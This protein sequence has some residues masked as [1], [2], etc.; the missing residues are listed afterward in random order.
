MTLSHSTITPATSISL[1]SSIQLV[2]GQFN[3]GQMIYIVCVADNNGTSGASSTSA[4]LTSS[5]GWTY[6]SR[7]TAL[8]DPGA[9]AAG[10][11]LYAWTAR[12]TSTVSET[13]T[14]NFSPNTTAKVV[15]GGGLDS[16]AGYVDLST[17][18]SATGSGT[19][20]TITTGS[21]ASGDV[22]IGIVG[23]ES[24]AAVTADSDT[25]NG[26]WGTQNT[27]VAD[28]LTE[29]TSQRFARQVKTVTGSGTQTYN[30]TL[31]ASADYIIAYLHFTEVKYDGTAAITQANNTSS[32]TATETFTGT[33]TVTQENDTSSI[34]A[35]ETFTGTVAST[36]EDDTATATGTSTTSDII[37]NAQV[38][39][40]TLTAVS[41]SSTTTATSTATNA[42]L[43]LTANSG[44][45]TTDRT[46]TNQIGFISLSGLVGTTTTEIVTDNQ[47]GNLYL[48]AIAGTISQGDIATTPVIPW[49]TDKRKPRRKAGRLVGRTAAFDRPA[50]LTVNINCISPLVHESEEDVEMMLLL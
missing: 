29:A 49:P 20:P 4:T 41:N 17:T 9:A 2:A 35:T 23:A 28:T 38:A 44:T 16:T 27:A 31:G 21:L 43:G 36:Q 3:V 18:S 42:N 10:L 47:I 33:A 40:I 12:V 46:V 19:A 8:N 30:P 7:Q 1:T 37:V 5:N 50:R 14:V 39:N 13:V 48:T 26:S 6:T 22:V 11:T 15:A 34:V 32:I 45:V 25:T 24:R